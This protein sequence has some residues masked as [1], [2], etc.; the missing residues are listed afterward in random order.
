MRPTAAADARSPR[1]D[2]PGGAFSASAPDAGGTGCP[3]R[4]LGAVR[5]AAQGAGG[6]SR[7]GAAGPC[8]PERAALVSVHTV[9]HDGLAAGTVPRSG[10]WAA[11]VLRPGAR[12]RWTR[13]AAVAWRLG[14]S[15][16][17][18]M[19]TARSPDRGTASAAQAPC[20]LCSSRTWS[21]PRTPRCCWS[22]R[23]HRAPTPAG[24]WNST[25][26][27]RAAPGRPASTTGAAPS[28]PPAPVGRRG[29][30]TAEKRASPPGF[31]IRTE[32]DRR[33][34]ATAG[35]SAVADRESPCGCH[36][37]RD[38]REPA[39][40]G[41]RLGGGEGIRVQGSHQTW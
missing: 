41:V 11:A 33:P 34:G 4:R 16:W 27:A 36:G 37:L 17:T 20:T 2:G 13:A 40:R 25:G 19:P 3:E 22:T 35:S 21:P 29:T 30:G 6:R 23:R 32:G 26:P 9:G 15:T 31:P 1:W 5:P 8:V 38:L 39:W 28:A 24:T 12:T 14:A 7:P 10:S 18:S